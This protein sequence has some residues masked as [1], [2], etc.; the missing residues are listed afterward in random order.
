MSRGALS[1]LALP[2]AAP[3]RL[4]ESWHLGMAPTCLEPRGDRQVL[5]VPG[6][7]RAGALHSRWSQ[8]RAGAQH[9]LTACPRRGLGPAMAMGRC[10]PPPARPPQHPTLYPKGAGMAAKCLPG[11]AGTAAGAP[12]ASSGSHPRQSPLGCRRGRAG[13]PSPSGKYGGRGTQSH[14]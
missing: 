13:G 1:S 9:P 8:S 2:V 7:S 11:A 6:I 14:Q 3:L 4:G 10:P 5:A 12:Q